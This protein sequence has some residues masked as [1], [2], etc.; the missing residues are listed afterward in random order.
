MEFLLKYLGDILQGFIGTVE[1]TL[2]GVFIGLALGTLL[3]IGDLYGRK[4]PQCLSAF[5]LNFSEEAQS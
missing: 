5:T 2:F 1:V 3:A 4:L